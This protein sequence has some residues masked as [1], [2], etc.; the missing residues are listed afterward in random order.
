MK[1]C[2]K[3]IVLFLC[4]AVLGACYKDLSTEATF[5]IPDIEITSESYP[6]DII[7]I[8]Y[9]QTLDISVD[10]KQEGRDAD[11]F[12]YLWEV[13]L[14]AG[15]SNDRQEIGDG[16]SVSYQV[17]SSP[18]DTPY[19]LTVCVT[20]LQTGYATYRKWN[21]YVVSSLGEGLLVAHTRNGGQT[22]ELDL[23]SCAP[24]TYGYEGDEPL[25]TR[26]L[27]ALANNGAVIEG[28]V[29]SLTARVAS[30]GAVFN[31][32][33]I[34]MAYGDHLCS[35]D[36][37]SYEVDKLDSEL[38]GLSEESTYNTSL[39]F[40]YAAYFSGAIVNGY[41]Y[42][43]ICN[44]DNSYSKASYSMD[45]SNIFTPYN[46]AY[47]KQDQGIVGV[48]DEVHSA[49]FYIYGWQS[50]SGG[51]TAVEGSTSFS[52]TGA[53]CVAAGCLSDSSLA[54]VLK[55]ADNTYHLCIV[56]KNGNNID[57]DDYALDAPE[58]DKAVS[59]GFCD[60]ADLFYYATENS[61]YPVIL[62]GD[63]ATVGN[64]LTWTP[65]NSEE[66]IT[67]IRQYQQGWYG[68]HQ[69]GLNDYEF[70]LST[71]RSQVI[72]TTYNETT[73]E[74]KIYLNPFV[75]STGRFTMSDNGVYGGFGEITAI[76]STLR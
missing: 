58:I 43:V 53:V 46:L 24:V 49:F 57:I 3:Y 64:A 70:I 56:Y 4:A 13:D 23:L 18:S 12:S 73:G 22:S 11:D 76:C 30:N 15:N 67:S 28:K 41:L 33:R 63:K 51:F 44:S 59:F 45:P 36:P 27:Y 31:E 50:A 54:F 75:V 71:N 60:N 32:S 7:N 10:V 47:A 6:D 20:D 55:A 35:I 19:T 48:F 21:M 26:N 39:A 74:G 37:I 52:L 2:F 40:N 68:T 38:F 72:I 65:E 34:M 61:I 17:A 66:K 42:V 16:P 29:N 5:Q 8:P 25:Y 1:T 14:V 9:G 69:Y 62:S